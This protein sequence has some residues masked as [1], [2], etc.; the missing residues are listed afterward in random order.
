MTSRATGL[1]I[2][3]ALILIACASKDQDTVDGRGIDEVANE[4]RSFVDELAKNVGT[5]PS[6]A[7]DVITDCAPG[8]KDSGKDLIYSVRVDVA[9]D[10]TERLQGAIRQEYESE[11]WTASVRKDNDLRLSRDNVTIGATVFADQ[12]VATVSG[13]GGCVR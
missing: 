12:G 13:T 9:A 6:V 11:G 10:T 4:A 8:Q 2:A 3:L 5:A 1:I 7:Q